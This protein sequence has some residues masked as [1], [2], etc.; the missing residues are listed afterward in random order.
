M[1]WALNIF[2]MFFGCI[3]IC[4]M[5]YTFWMIKQN[6]QLKIKVFKL[7]MEKQNKEQREHDA[8]E[9]KMKFVS[10]KI[11]D[12]LNKKVIG[13]TGTG[14]LMIGRFV[15]LEYFDKSPS[16][17][18]GIPLIEDAV[19]NR[20][21]HFGKVFLH[22]SQLERLLTEM[23]TEDRQAIIWSTYPIGHYLSG[24]EYKG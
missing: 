1:S 22:T 3:G 20:S 13:I 2:L 21:I 15:G 7:E 9:N 8:L 5:V 24:I 14:E 19:G 4:C 23:P 6:I 10:F 16:D 17:Q 11:Q 18:E 12:N